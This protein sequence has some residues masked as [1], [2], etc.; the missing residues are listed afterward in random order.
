V[1]AAQQAPHHVGAHSAEPDHSHLHF[2]PLLVERDL[3]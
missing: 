3:Y 2:I 1:T